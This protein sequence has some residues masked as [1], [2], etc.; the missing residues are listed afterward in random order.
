MNETIVAQSKNL[1]WCS[2]AQ[3]DKVIKFQEDYNK[4]TYCV[5]CEC[6]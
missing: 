1:K 3:C 2:N 4:I 6:G 5:K